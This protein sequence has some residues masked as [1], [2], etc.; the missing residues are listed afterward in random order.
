MGAFRSPWLRP[1]FATVDREDFAPG[2]FWI[3]SPDGDGLL[4][5]VDRDK[6]QDAWRKAVWNTHLPLVTQMDDGRT[7]AEG[8]AKGDFSS[9]ISGMDIVFEKLN[10][11]DLECGHKVLHIGTASGY[12]TALLCE[13]TGSENVTTV[14]YDPVLAAWGAKNLEDA[15]YSAEV[16]CGN[17]LEG[18]AR[19]GPYHRLIA[20]CSVRDIPKQWREQTADGGIILTPFNTRY[21]RG[22]L[23]KLQVLSGVASGRFVGGAWY[24]WARQHR[25]ENKL[26]PVSDARYEPSSLDPDEVFGVGWPTDF[27]LGLHVPGISF[28]SRGEGEDRKVQLWDETGRSVA[29]VNYGDWYGSEAVCVYGERNLWVEVVQAFTAWKTAG[30]PHFTR[31]GLTYDDVGSRLWLDEPTNIVK[32]FG[33]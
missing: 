24:M 30:S 29:I 7:V 4:P 8:P 1:A 6:D 27:V 17:G 28:S 11:L 10:R 13:G 32:R 20:T 12:D 33:D 18:W 15:G 2:A 25:P 22:G 3:N 19:S 26:S 5:V 23:L 16:I 31:Y 21:A 14:E 9:S